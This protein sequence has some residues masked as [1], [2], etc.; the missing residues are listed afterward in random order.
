VR[1]SFR[2]T[3]LASGLGLLLVLA[4]AAAAANGGF[5]PVAPRTPN[6][7]RINDA[8]WY[9]FGF[10]AF[11]FVVVEVAL[12]VFVVRFR[13]RGRGREVEGPQIRGN[14]NLELAWT[15]GP[16]LILAAIAAFVFYKLPGIKNVPPASA[17]STQL[18][19][20]VEA[21][22]FYWQFD[23]PGGAI[24][25]DRLVV[26]QNEVVRLDVVSPTSRTAGGSRRSAARSTRSRAGR[27]TPGSRSHGSGRTRASARSSA[28]CCTPG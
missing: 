1:A 8:Y 28:A 10:A 2:A 9:I 24:S 20:K 15:A 17:G 13:S 27:T 5:S 21:H 7:E 26:P 23:Y 11:V 19:V 18:R 25:I 6:G 3:V 4:G 16:V 12:V 22:Q 14:T